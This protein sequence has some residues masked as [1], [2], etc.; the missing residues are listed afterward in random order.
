MLNLL[1]SQKPKR[2]HLVELM[3]VVVIIVLVAIAIPVY[4]NVTQN[5]S[6]EVTA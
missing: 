2:F 6:Y 1:K 3:V 4:N 5:K